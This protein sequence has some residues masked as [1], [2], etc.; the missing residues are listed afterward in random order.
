M[1]FSNM[2][3][4]VTGRS[5]VTTTGIPTPTVSPS[6]GA[7]AAKVCSSRVRSTVLKVR[8]RSTLRPSDRV[9]DAVIV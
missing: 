8:V 9:A 3:R 7:T 2:A 5:K 6:S 4:S 1:C